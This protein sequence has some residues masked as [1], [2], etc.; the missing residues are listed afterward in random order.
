MPRNQAAASG[1]AVSSAGGLKRSNGSTT[2]A[3]DAPA[4][5]PR[6]AVSAP[7]RA[8]SALRPHDEQQ[9]QQQQQPG[10]GQ[11]PPPA[12]AEQPPAGRSQPPRQPASGSSRQGQPPPD[13]LLFL[14]PYNGSQGASQGVLTTM[15]LPPT[16]QA[17]PRPSPH[18]EVVPE[19]PIGEAEPDVTA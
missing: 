11:H 16:H 6:A 13:V 9:Q 1:M 2:D 14:W 3:A 5:R 19:T 18:A 4:K 10:G 12:A 7:A 8:A 15:Q 17:V